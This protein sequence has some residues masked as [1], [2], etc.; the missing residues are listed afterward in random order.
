LLDKILLL[1]LYFL[2]LLRLDDKKVIVGIVVAV[3]FG[4]VLLYMLYLRCYI[5]KEGTTLLCLG[6]KVEKMVIHTSIP[7]H[8][9]TYEDTSTENILIENVSRQNSFANNL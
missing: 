8:D 6:E 5:A 2:N 3:T 7:L 4:F 1:I 9:Q